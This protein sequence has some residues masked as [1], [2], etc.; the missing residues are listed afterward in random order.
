MAVTDW[1]VV[2]R[3][4]EMVTLA[5]DGATLLIE[6]PRLAGADPLMDELIG[7]LAPHLAFGDVQLE[8][9]VTIREAV[10]RRDGQPRTSSERIVVGRYTRGAMSIGFVLASPAPVDI[11]DVLG[12]TLTD[13][14][15]PFEHLT[16]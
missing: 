8:N 1:R 3:T 16:D 9:G 6:S 13:T 2:A 4:A 14:R 15:T 5:T 10:S 7:R 11:T 12:A